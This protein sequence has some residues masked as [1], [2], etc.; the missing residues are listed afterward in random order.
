MSGS[1]PSPLREEL[2]CCASNHVCVRRPL[3]ETFKAR[4]WLKW[5]CIRES[6]SPNGAKMARFSRRG[7]L[8]CLLC[9]KIMSF[10]VKL[11][12]G[13]YEGSCPP[14]F[15]RR[16]AKWSSEKHS[17]G[18]L[19]VKCHLKISADI[20]QIYIERTPRLFQTV[21]LGL[22]SSMQGHNHLA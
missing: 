12:R 4:S 3:G 15:E 6:M 22:D 1:P 16:A 10:S 20:V 18:R 21:P 2:G 14:M 11:Q 7:I 17:V 8:N 13:D 9:T 19:L 5:C